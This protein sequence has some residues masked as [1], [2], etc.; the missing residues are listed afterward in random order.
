LGKLSINYLDI[1][2]NALQDEFPASLAG[3]DSYWVNGLKLEGNLVEANDPTTR[4]QLDLK[5][6]N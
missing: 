4:S 1:S 6:P 5:D 3:L 2:Y